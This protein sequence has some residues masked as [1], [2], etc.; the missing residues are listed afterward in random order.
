[1][2]SGSA[3]L[4]PLSEALR[5]RVVGQLNELEEVATG[6]DVPA[7][8]LTESGSGLD[9]HITPRSARLQVPRIS[10]AT[11]VDAGQIMAL[12][13]RE[14]HGKWLGLFGLE[15]VNV[16]RL[17]LELQDLAGESS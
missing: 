10:R 9:P 15:R 2:N 8:W 7:E 3:N 12:I 6:E 17:N 5:E 14:T 4:G 11:G 1:M 16:L 13:E